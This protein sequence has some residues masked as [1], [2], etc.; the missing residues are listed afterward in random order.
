MPREDPSRLGK[1]QSM[2]D[3]VF[4]VVR[5]VAELD[6]LYASETDGTRL[7]FYCGAQEPPPVK[8]PIEQHALDCTWLAARHL[9]LIRPRSPFEEA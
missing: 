6:P 8:N 5:K 9:A 3:D 4:D 1:L 7:C 2:I